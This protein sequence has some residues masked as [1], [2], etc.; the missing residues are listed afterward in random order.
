MKKN[1][2][3]LCL[4][5]IL[6]TGANA[7]SITK[8]WTIQE[9]VAHALANNISV[10][11]TDLENKT[12]AVEKIAAIGGFLPTLN[13]NTSHSW[14]IGLN[15]NI[16]TGLLENQTTQFTSAGV[17]ANIVIY[18]GLQNINRLRRANLSILS[19]QYQL[20]KMKDD[21][22]LNVANSFLQILFNRENLKVQQNQLANN[23]KQL[24]RS[25][26]LVAAGTLPK[27]DLL[28]LEANIATNKQAI[29]AAENVLF[30]SR[31][32]L[33]QLLQLKDFQTFDISDNDYAVTESA[34]MLQS[35]EAILERARN[36]RMELKI[37]KANLEIAQKDVIIAKGAYQPTISGFY[38]F[39][40]RAS[41]NSRIIDFVPNTA[42]P[43]S[44]IGF[45]Q[46]TNQTVLQQNFVPVVGNALPIFDQFSNNKGNIFGLQLNIPII[47][48]FATRNNVARAKINVER[49]QIT[50]SQQE[51][52]LQLNVYTAITDAKGSL[53]SYEA[54][55]VSLEAREQA[56]NFAKNRFEAGLTN[57]FDLNQAQTLFV[58][59]QS[60]VVKTKFD[61]I[62]KVKVVEFYFGIQ[63]NKN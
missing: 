14:N 33:A 36:E 28:D 3:F 16:T 23:E 9:C 12:A 19:A 26:E 53:K 21:I 49:S 10:K 45:V 35:P 40:T 55:K 46:G 59:A 47:N 8:K 43:T 20:S 31:L 52:T 54:A 34:A 15:Q 60:E 13:A 24:K 7:Q 18:N 62:F 4:I 2:Q 6:C 48:G 1:I 27:G 30:L 25:Q 32:S 57:A 39:N 5:V 50:Y 29:V 11:Q 63:V 61:Y 37:A 58:N 17:N 56:Y 44:P 42:R 41:D 38:S 51:L 22:S